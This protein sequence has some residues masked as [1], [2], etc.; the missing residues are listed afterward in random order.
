MREFRIQVENHLLHI[1]PLALAAEHGQ[2]VLLLLPRVVTVAVDCVGQR[3]RV[4][5]VVVLIDLL[6]MKQIKSEAT[7]YSLLFVTAQQRRTSVQN[8]I[9]NAKSASPTGLPLRGGESRPYYNS[10]LLVI[11][12]SAYFHPFVR[13]LPFRS[14]MRRGDP[15]VPPIC[16]EQRA[17]PI[18]CREESTPH[19]PHGGAPQC[20]NP[21][22]TYHSRDEL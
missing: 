9:R 11:M 17:I 10:T 5:F 12:E 6:K 13:V 14:L 7:S 21:L 19:T 8:L 20:E 1:A 15:N 18:R 4:V 22:G 2:I 3:L 16:F